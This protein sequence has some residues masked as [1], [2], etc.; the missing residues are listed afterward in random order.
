MRKLILKKINISD[1]DKMSEIFTFIHNDC[2]YNRVNE[3]Y[4]SDIISNSRYE[5]Y[6]L[7]FI[8]RLLE[9][10]EIIGYII[11]YDTSDEIDL[12]EIA[13]SRKYQ[14]QGYGKRL[15]EGGIEILKENLKQLRDKESKNRI[16]LEVDET[17]I[18][19]MGL[20][21]KIGFKK[22][23]IRKNYYGQNRNGIIMEKKLIL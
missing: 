10:P 17:N 11:F 3:D 2:F 1:V 4:F 5:I 7:S 21:E 15:I 20:Y 18:K 23:A 12:F 8:D 16:L 6:I 19:A 13:V 14:G 22:I 9:N